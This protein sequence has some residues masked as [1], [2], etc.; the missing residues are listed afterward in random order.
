[1]AALG[2]SLA[3]LELLSLVPQLKTGGMLRPLFKSN[4]GGSAFGVGF[5]SILQGCPV[6][7]AVI[8]L[9]LSAALA[10]IAAI[11]FHRGQLLPLLIYVM[12]AAF[13]QLRKGLGNNGSDEM[14]TLTL[15]SVFIARLF[16]TSFATNI[17]LCFI[18][19]QLSLSY[20][21]AGVIKLGA[22]LWRDGQSLT[23]LMS[24]QTFGNERLYRFLANNPQMAILASAAVYGGEILVAFAP[25]VPSPV[26][27]M[28][29]G[30]G[31]VFHLLVALTMGLNTFLFA[32]AAAYPAALYTSNLLYS[33]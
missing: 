20:F 13:L 24:T 5:L 3:D 1:M 22:P 16:S 21:T 18:A 10:C 4:A 19:L 9:R 30:S 6:G 17:A 2:S 26:G 14:L 7:T 32:F 23:A 27:L 8:A 31:L 25:W 15:I 33:R 29:L 11:A 28:L 12:A